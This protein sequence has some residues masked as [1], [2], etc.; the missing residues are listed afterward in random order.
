MATMAQMQREAERTRTANL[1]AQA[2]AQRDAERAR[3]AYGRAQV[4]DERERK[5]LYAESRLADVAA[6]NEELGQRLAELDGLLGATLEVDDYLDLNS[7]KQPV[8][9]PDFDENAFG[10][11]R[12]PPVLQTYLPTAPTGVGKMFGGGKHTEAVRAAKA[13]FE[14]DTLQYRA[15]VD[16]RDRQLAD[17]RV[18][19]QAKVAELVNEARRHHAEIDDLRQRL[20][21]GAPDAVVAYLALVLEAASYPDGF[22]HTWRLAFVPESA[23]L[24]VE[25][26]LPGLDVIPQVKAY[27][28]AKAS[29][30]VAETARPL[31]QVRTQYA[32]VVA[33]TA[34]RVV[35]ELLEADRAGHVGTV[36]LNGMVSTVDPATGRPVHPCLLTLRTTRATFEELDLGR[37]DPAACLRHLG[38]GVSRSPAELTPVRPVLEFD[39]VDPRFIAEDDVLSGLDDRPN[40]LEMTPGDFEGLIQNLFA[41]MGLESKLTRASRDGGVDCVAYDP[42]PIMG[43]KVVIQAKRYRHT[44]GVSAVRD[45]FGTLQNE[46]ASKGI[47]VTTS[48]YGQ[49]SFDF[50]ANKPIELLDG[51]NLL[52]LLRE[53]A[54]IEA[55][56]EVPPEWVEPVAD[57]PDVVISPALPSVTPSPPAV[58]ARADAVPAADRQLT[59]GENVVLTGNQITA[60]LHASQSSNV[61]GFDLSVLLLGEDGRVSGDA[62]FVFYNN[63]QAAD[64]AVLLASDAGSCRLD[65]GRVSDA[66]QRLV[67]VAS[68]DVASNG[69]AL[70]RLT[71]RDTDQAVLSFAP[72]LSTMLPALLCGEMYRRQGAWRFRAVGQG[73]ADGLAGLARDFGVDVE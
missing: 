1:R 28:Y 36:V 51:A 53:H 33:Q 2:K 38:A 13:Q 20:E 49:A 52:Y 67:L 5:R 34:L 24:V 68:P 44:V 18:R 48:G 50:A 62:D 55:R 39:M 4:A 65:L 10:A 15:W 7:L 71:V 40:L 61:G 43:G 42:R 60:Y 19:H 8:K 26:E 59:A 27:K 25:Y 64:G 46:G 45:L 66:V 23:Q 30:T 54:G 6:S 32:S 21:A 14:A 37:V 63:P 41:R 3:A 47:L 12:P 16:E 72:A 56:I 58:S 73:Y 35:H 11:M 9:L 17:A 70:P 29:D 57:A 22:P 69:D 31:A